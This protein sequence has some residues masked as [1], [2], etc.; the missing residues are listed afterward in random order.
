MKAF[1]LKY[2]IDD[3]TDTAALEKKIIA[4]ATLHYLQV[5]KWFGDLNNL[6]VGGK[7]YQVGYDGAGYLHTVLGLTEEEVARYRRPVQWMIYIYRNLDSLGCLVQRIDKYIKPNHSAYIL[8]RSANSLL[9]LTLFIF[10]TEWVI[11]FFVFAFFNSSSYF[12]A[13][14]TTYSLF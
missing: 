6:W 1:G 14:T 10:F 3:S 13:L 12:I 8:I 9:F 4:Y 11:S 5:H 2:N 7:Y